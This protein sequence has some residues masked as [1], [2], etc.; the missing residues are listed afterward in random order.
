MMLNL[1]W[2]NLSFGV[3]IHPSQLF[4]KNTQI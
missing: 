3:L 1:P 2:L 4:I